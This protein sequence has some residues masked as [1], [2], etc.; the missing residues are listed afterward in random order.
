MKALAQ[1]QKEGFLLRRGGQ[2]LRVTAA[3][4]GGWVAVVLLNSICKCQEYM[5]TTWNRAALAK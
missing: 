1:F 2:Q 4:V 3:K 5:G